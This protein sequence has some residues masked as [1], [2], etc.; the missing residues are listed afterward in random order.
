MIAVTGR[1]CTVRSGRLR[2]AGAALVADVQ[3]AVGSEIVRSRRGRRRLRVTV[4][5][6]VV[7]LRAQQGR[8]RLVALPA[9][10][11]AQQNGL[12]FLGAGLGPRT[13]GGS[14]RGF[15]LGARARR[16][17][18]RGFGLGPG[19]GRRREGRTRLGASTACRLGLGC[20]VGERDSRERQNGSDDGETHPTST[21]VEP[22]SFKS[23][24]PSSTWIDRD[25]QAHAFSSHSCS[26]RP[27]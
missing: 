12:F 18:Q 8:R 1:A 25:P 23:L 26:N 17:R 2:G 15:G 19:A 4:H 3:A 24:R 7:A 9:V 6:R 22:G 20:G 5:V 27:P 13:G 11:R 21:Y 14:G 16:G 10:G